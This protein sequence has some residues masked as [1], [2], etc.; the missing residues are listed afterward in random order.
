M[1]GVS[2]RSARTGFILLLSLLAVAA[3]AKAILY[4]TL[5]PDLFWHLRVA[6]DLS[7]QAFV[8]P[9]IDD[10]SFASIRTPWTPYSWLA[11]L[12]M[13][14][15]WDWGGFRS[16]VLA[17]A[18]IAAGLVTLIGMSALETARIRGRGGEYLA[19]SLAAFCGGFLALPY[20]SFRPV[21]LALLLI[22]VC[23]WLMLRDMRMK[24]SSRAVWLIIPIT[25]VLINIHLYAVFVPAACSARLIEEFCHRW[26]QIH[27]DEI[28]G[29]SGSWVSKIAYL[30]ASVSICGKTAFLFLGAL[31]ACL[32][33]PMLPGVI[34]AAWNYQ[35]ADVM[36][37]GGVIAEMHP[38]YQG[39][40]GWVATG[41]VMFI[42]IAAVFRRRSLSITQ[43]LWIG[44][45]SLALLRLGRFAPIFAIFS[46]P[47]LGAT[48][49]HLSAR[50]LSRRW[51][52]TALALL[53]IAAMV[54]I[55]WAF[56][57]GKTPLSTWL[58][59]QEVGGYPVNATEYVLRSVPRRTGRMICEFTWGGY[60]EWRLGQ[61]WQVLMDGR[62]QVYT[63]EFWRTVYLG[64]SQ[65]RKAYLSTLK[66]DAAVLPTTGSVFADDLTEL[67]WRVVWKDGRAE[68]MVPPGDV[69][70]SN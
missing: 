40:F 11:D 42:V 66:A 58:N 45:S 39:Q 31:L 5:D 63:A 14:R 7:K 20:L 43:W 26:T 35:F 49:P 32:M 22:A 18:L 9:L 46:T 2:S 41:I 6:D 48:L 59:R 62:T 36:V 70:A 55:G 3:G 16:A 56:P 4:D 17:Q 27:T 65:N 21:T 13:K 47:S 44:G 10:L 64:D 53:L 34:A 29:N 28:R 57:T 15:L 69:A 33:T 51:T 30:C 68:V 24:D 19:A 60:L 25:A 1:E 50:V 23:V 8:H 61:N 12:G 38:F 67:G 52:Q 54:R 37:R